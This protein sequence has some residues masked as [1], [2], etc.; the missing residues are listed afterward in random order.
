MLAIAA[1]CYDA[2]PLR[3]PSYDAAIYPELDKGAWEELMS[4]TMH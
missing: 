1:R 4:E 3:G 2:I